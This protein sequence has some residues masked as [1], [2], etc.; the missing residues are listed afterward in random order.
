M[1]WDTCGQ[2]NR[3]HLERASAMVQAAVEAEP[4]NPAYLDSLGW[5]Y[6]RLNQPEN[7]LAELKKAVAEMEEPDGVILDHLGDV[8]QALGQLDQARESWQQAA[9]TAPE[10]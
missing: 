9:D 4:D 10:K 6:F 1:I 7:A 5:V 2:T 8:Y 3:T